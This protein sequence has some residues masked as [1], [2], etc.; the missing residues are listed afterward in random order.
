MCPTFH[1]PH[2]SGRRKTVKKKTKCLLLFSTWLRFYFVLFDQMF[3][4]FLEW[5][6]ILYCD[7]V[8]CCRQN[9]NTLRRKNCSRTHLIHNQKLFNGDMLSFIQVTTDHTAPCSLSPRHFWPLELTC[10]AKK[11]HVSDFVLNI[12]LRHLDNRFQLSWKA[13]SAS[14]TWT[15][16]VDKPVKRKLQKLSRP[17]PW[18]N[19]S[20][21]LCCRSPPWGDIPSTWVTSG[22]QQPERCFWAR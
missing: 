13:V 19:L 14:L 16:S 15:V 22:G 21:R 8:T 5:V 10:R 1:K 4:S 2:V 11:L 20:S 3:W 18:N 12:F 7:H 6:F 9:K 17:L